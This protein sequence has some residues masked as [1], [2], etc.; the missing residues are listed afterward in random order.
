VAVFSSSFENKG[1]VLLHSIIHDITEQKKAE[2]QIA[3]SLQEKEVLLKEI[4]HRVK[5]NMNVI[6]SLLNLEASRTTDKAVRAILKEAQDRV[7]MMALIHK[8][9][10]QSKDL[11]HIDYKEYL[12]TLVA[13]I[14][15]TYHRHDVIV[16]VDMESLFFDVTIGIPCGLIVNELVSNSLKYAFPE[17]RK[18]TIK[19]G[20][21][22]DSEGNNVLTVADDGVGFPDTVDFR[23][24][25]SL[26]LQLVSMLTGQIHGKVALSRGEGTRFSITF[27]GK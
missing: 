21:N 16:T 23:K 25:T 14:T 2:E 7:N 5:N 24:T 15:D 11:A 4:H 27:P 3:R 10:Y 18:G 6:S 13:G 12:Q 1:N 19:V 8:K 17:G 22:K 26:G 9:L 20:I